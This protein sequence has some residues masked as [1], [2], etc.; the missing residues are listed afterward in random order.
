MI[1]SS[2]FTNRQ[3]NDVQ[4]FD[5]IQESN[6]ECTSLGDDYK[7]KPNNKASNPN[8]TIIDDGQR[9]NDMNYPIQ[10]YTNRHNGEVD[11]NMD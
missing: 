9:S 10:D 4:G 7:S 1:N 11:I 3:Q 8:I 2:W 6:G 5:L